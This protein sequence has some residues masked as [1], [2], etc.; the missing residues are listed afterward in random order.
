MPLVSRIKSVDYNTSPP[1]FNSFFRNMAISNIPSA[2]EDYRPSTS[3]TIK[4]FLNIRYSFQ[5]SRIKRPYYEGRVKKKKTII[6]LSMGKD[7]LLTLAV[8]KEIGLAPVCVYINDTV[9]PAENRLKLNFLKKIG[10]E[11]GLKV[12]AVVNEIENLN[13]FEYWNKGESCIGYSH[14]ICGF[15]F[16]VLPVSHY[17]QAK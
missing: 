2:V 12:F 11:F 1:L 3:D 17:F 10:R 5:N 7:S 8:S 16:V 4:Q 14:M 9:S 6:P 13:D 15:C